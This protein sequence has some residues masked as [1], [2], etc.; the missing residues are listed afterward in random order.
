MG[1]H[2]LGWLAV[3]CYAAAEVS[4][5]VWLARPRSLAGRAA[6]A[7]ISA[8]L[9]LHFSD[10]LNR[11]R[12]LSSVP[13]R[14]LG[15]S[16]SFFGWMLG[17]AYLALALRHRERADGTVSHP[18]DH[19]RY[20]GRPPSPGSVDAPG[21]GRPRL[22]LRISRDARDPRVRGLCPVVRDLHPLP[23][24][25]PPDPAGPDGIPLLPPAA[26]RGPRPDEPHQ[27]LHRPRG[28]RAGARA[29]ASS[30]PSRSGRPS[31][32]PR[33]SGPFSRWPCT[34]CCCGWTGAAGRDRGSRFFRSSASASFSSPT[35]S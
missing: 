7:L 29:R 3:A 1:S 17:I 28:P 13:Y 26:A 33:S 4:A 6:L 30:G 2:G 21:P 16:V 31:P 27:R 5:I 24:P 22:P 8:G 14:T 19:R 11:A 12:A 34:G 10:L 15:G 25:E 9:A 18:A 23:R 32:T 35:R 20:G